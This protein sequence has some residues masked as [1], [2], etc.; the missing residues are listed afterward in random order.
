MCFRCGRLWLNYTELR[1]KQ[2]ASSTIA[3]QP[4]RFFQYLGELLSRLC[5]LAAACT[6]YIIVILLPVYGALSVYYG[7]HQ[8]EYAWSVSGT[9]LSGAVPFG[10]I[11]VTYTALMLY[12]VAWFQRTISHMY[13][14]ALAFPA[15]SRLALLGNNENEAVLLLQGQLR[16]WMVYGA[17]IMVNVSIVAGVNIAYVYAAL[18]EDSSTFAVVQVAMSVF[19]LVW[20]GF[21][22]LKLTRMTDHYLK[23]KETS[24]N[25]LAV[26]LFVALF[27]LIAIPC[28]IVAAINPKLLRESS[29][30]ATASNF[31][32]LLSRLRRVLDALWLP[33]VPTESRD[34]NL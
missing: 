33:P 27:N 28:I 24:G 17:F 5:E 25:F 22:A 31:A 30:V 18:Y 1:E 16:Q 29:K 15:N 19:K 12:T 7:T 34:H 23:E 11:L 13:S 4:M 2:N 8:F 14:C 9:F 32:I 3:M 10:I 20:N 21:F 26:Q 6:V